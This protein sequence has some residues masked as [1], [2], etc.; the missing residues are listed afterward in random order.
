MQLRDYQY[1]FRSN[2]STYSAL[3]EIVD[4]ITIW[5]DNDKYIIGVFIEIN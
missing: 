2:R 3:L 4:K 1:G 5:I